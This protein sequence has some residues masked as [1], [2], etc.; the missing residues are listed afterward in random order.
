MKR[1]YFAVFA[2]I[3]LLM[4]SACGKSSIYN[5]EGVD[6]DLSKVSSVVAYA[7]VYNIYQEYESYFGKVIRLKGTF[8]V[9]YD[10]EKDVNYFSCV[11]TDEMACCSLSMEFVLAGDY[12]YPEEYPQNG[13]SVTVTGVFGVYEEEGLLYC[14][15]TDAYLGEKGA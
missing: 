6:I 7:E 4:T 10:E 5:T 1:G 12:S 13:S 2:V 15:L 11:V 9:Y 3:L 14:Q 8:D